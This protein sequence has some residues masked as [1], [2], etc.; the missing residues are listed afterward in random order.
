MPYLNGAVI[1]DEDLQ[2]RLGKYRA[3]NSGAPADDQS[4]INVWE[5]KATPNW[6]QPQQQAAPAPA[7]APMSPAAAQ[8]AQP[9]MA[10]TIQASVAGQKVENNERDTSLWG[11]LWKRASQ[12]TQVDPN[13]ANVKAQT[14]A[15]NTEA[16]RASRDHIA[17]LAESAGPYANLQGEARMAAERVGEGTGRVRAQLVGQELQAI[18]QEKAQAYAALQ[19]KL[20]ADEDRALREELS[21]LD[22]QLKEQ[23]FGLQ[24]QG[25]NQNWQ[26]TLLQNE[27]FQDS[28]GLQAEDRASYWD[29]IRRGVL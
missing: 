22:A 14:D 21:V 6:N 17:N 15:Y 20:T 16:T 11:D 29:A 18:R 23:G 4:I 8:A 27:Q 19:G 12:S 24:Q 5:G 7:A 3:E 28:L 9:P 13:N 2:G 1:S 25:L 26:S 10:S